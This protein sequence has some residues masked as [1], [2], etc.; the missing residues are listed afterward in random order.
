MKTI[1]PPGISSNFMGTPRTFVRIVQEPLEFFGVTSPS[2]TAAK[3]PGGTA[4]RLDRESDFLT[5]FKRQ[6][7]RYPQDAAFVGGFNFQ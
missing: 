6:F 7:L 5:F 1:V 3:P 4:D 2:K